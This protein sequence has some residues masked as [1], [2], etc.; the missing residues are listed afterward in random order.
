MAVSYKILG[1]SAPSATTETDLYTV[2]GSNQAV[3]SSIIVCN[4]GGSSTTF[5]VSCSV[6][7]AA[8]ANKDYIYYDVLIAANDT[9]IATIGITLDTSDKVRVYAGN[10]NLSFT[11]VGSEITI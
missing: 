6:A 11:L 2:P 3:G 1:Q 5:R 9:F 7:G 4:R 8:T 10:G